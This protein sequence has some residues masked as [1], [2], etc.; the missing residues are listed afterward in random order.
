MDYLVKNVGVHRGAPRL[1]FQSRMLERCGMTRGTRFNLEA[2]DA[3]ITLQVDPNGTRVVSG[4]DINGHTIPVIDINAANDLSGIAG[5]QAVKV[6]FGE[7]EIRISPL[8]SEVAV[9][10]RFER[11]K[12]HVA[13]GSLTAAGIAFGGGIIDKAVHDGFEEAGVQLRTTAVNEIYPDLVEHACGAN[14]VITDGTQLIAAPMQEFVQDPAA[15]GRL[16][17]TDVVIAGIPCSGASKSG[18]SKNGISMMEA[19]PEVGH[20]VAPFLM[21]MVRLQPAVFVLENV[22]DYA[23]TASA[24]IIRQFMRDMGY[25]IDEVTLNGKDFGAIEARQ[26]WFMV[27]ATRGVQLDLEGLRAEEPYIRTV[28]EILDPDVDPSSWSPMEGLRAKEVRDKA[29]GKG[30][31]MQIVDE[32]ATTVGTIGKGYAKN[33]STEPKLQH[34]TE[35]NL[36]RLFTGDEHARLKGVDPSLVAGLSNTVKHVVLGQGVVPGPVIALARRIAECIKRSVT[37]NSDGVATTAGYSLAR[38]VG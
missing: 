20:L 32:H 3:I 11:L 26:R 21:L 37:G 29:A 35:P 10:E 9:R 12:E 33:R 30:F 22:P 17:K 8:A 14:P 7:N 34:P 5:M 6:E 25:S 28:G 27:G 24:Q 13:E 4:K 15:M 19:H 18:K 23:N 2:K 38:A 31:A 16:R 1:Y 36:L